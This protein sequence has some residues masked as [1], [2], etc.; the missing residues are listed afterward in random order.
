MRTL[1]AGL[2]TCLDNSIS[3]DTLPQSAIDAY[4]S[5]DSTF[6]NNVE[7][8]LLSVNGNYIMG[9]KGVIQSIDNFKNEKTTQMTLLQKQIDLAAKTLELAK[10]NYS[11]YEA[12]ATGKINATSTQTSIAQKQYEMSQKQYAEALATID[13]LKKQKTLQLSQI[14]TQLS[15]IKGTKDMAGISVSNNTILAP[16]DGIITAKTIALGQIVAPGLPLFTIAKDETVKVKI[17]V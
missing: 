5:Q 12:T 13:T 8:S 16:F 3:S 6:R 7:Q 10:Q 17:Y 15:Q 4:K 14:Q 1:T 9:I 2:Y 11:Q